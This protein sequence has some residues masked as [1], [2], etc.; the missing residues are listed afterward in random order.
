[1]NWN[2]NNSLNQLALCSLNVLSIFGTLCSLNVLST[3]VTINYVKI[4]I[5]ANS[6][7]E[8]YLTNKSVANIEKNFPNNSQ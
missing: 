8:K 1:M 5:V 2:T 3:S 4:V 6:V 7:K